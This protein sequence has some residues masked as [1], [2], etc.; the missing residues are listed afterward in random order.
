MRAAKLQKKE[1]FI[2]FLILEA[3]KSAFIF[4]SIKVVIGISGKATLDQ[5]AEGKYGRRVGYYH[6]DT[7]RHQGRS[8]KALVLLSPRTGREAQEGDSAF[9]NS[10]KSRYWQPRAV[11]INH[12]V[13]HFLFL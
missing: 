7:E 5:E 6:G 11:T 4:L 1:P 9:P 12:S 13:N 2:A 8:A 3:L 10:G